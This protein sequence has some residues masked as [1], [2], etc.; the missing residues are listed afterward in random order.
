MTTGRTRQPLTFSLLLAAVL[1]GVVLAGAW[2]GEKLNWGQAIGSVI[3][4][5]GLVLGLSRQLRLRRN[6]Q[7]KRG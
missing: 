6:P 4:V 5:A 7:G 3:I 2:L 1:F